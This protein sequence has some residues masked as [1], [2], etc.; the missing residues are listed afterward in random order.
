MH[1]DAPPV[2]ATSTTSAKASEPTHVSVENGVETYGTANAAAS[3]SSSSSAG[4][5]AALAPIQ[6]GTPPPAAPV[7]DEEDDLSAP[8]P[9][10]A[11]CKRRAC[12][13]V[14]EGEAVSRGQGEKAKCTYHPLGVSSPSPLDLFRG[15]GLVES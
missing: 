5:A 4:A 11:K 12:G 1:T 14:W 10:G 7:V 2:S 8:V 13:A 3:S 15:L 9:E 6:A